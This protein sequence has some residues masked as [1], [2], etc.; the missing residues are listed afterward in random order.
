M[1][2]LGDPRLIKLPQYVDANGDGL[3]VATEAGEQVPFDQ[4]QRMFTIVAPA[5]SKRGR[6]AHRLCS[7]F[8]LCVSGAM[9][10]TCDDGTDRKMFLLDRSEFALFVPPGIWLEIDARQKDSVLIVLCDR[11]Y[12]ERD[13]IRDYGEFLSFRKTPRA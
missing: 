5:G 6:H 13:Y 8:M 2:E 12:E 9:D 7:Q 4:I 10:I 3:L 11:L 1:N